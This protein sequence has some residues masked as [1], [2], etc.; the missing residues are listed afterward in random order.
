MKTATQAR[1]SG[2]CLR[3]GNSRSGNGATGPYSATPARIGQ[4][5][6]VQNHNRNG[7]KKSSLKQDG[8][9]KPFYFAEGWHHIDR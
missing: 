5:Q 2:Q 1:F 4:N 9:V 8:G 7:V 6:Y 3:T